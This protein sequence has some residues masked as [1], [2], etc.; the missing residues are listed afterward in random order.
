MEQ[1]GHVPDILLTETDHT[2]VCT[3]TCMLDMTGIKT[4]YSRLRSFN[5]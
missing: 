3:C 2:H 4:S 1:L 5:C